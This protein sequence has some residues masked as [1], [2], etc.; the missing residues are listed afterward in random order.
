MVA[1]HL[2]VDEMRSAVA[3]A[4]SLMIKIHG[5]DNRLSLQLADLEMVEGSGIHC[6]VYPDEGIAR[7]TLI[8][9]PNN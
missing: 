2:S 3:A 7:F 5:K 4:L 6:E 9:R 8:E 1:T